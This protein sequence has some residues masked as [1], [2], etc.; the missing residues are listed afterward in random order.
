MK[1]VISLAH[2]IAWASVINFRIEKLSCC[3]W[4]RERAVI[5]PEKITNP[6][7]SH[8][9]EPSQKVISAT[10]VCEKNPCTGEMSIQ[11]C[12]STYLGIS[13]HQRFRKPQYHR[14]HV[15]TLVCML[16]TCEHRWVDDFF[17]PWHTRKVVMVAA[18]LIV[19]VAVRKAGFI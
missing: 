19:V 18:V 17:E 6:L 12:L 1:Y 15:F 8:W 14:L 2:Q 11:V 5:E 10:F 9:I 3:R 4:E 16:W 7:S 13:M